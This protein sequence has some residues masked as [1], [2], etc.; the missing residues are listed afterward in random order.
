MS[1]SPSLKVLHVTLHSYWEGG[2]QV[3]SIMLLLTG[4][5]VLIF[6]TGKEWTKGSESE[7]KCFGFYGQDHRS[8]S[9][10]ADFPVMDVVD[11]IL[12]LSARQQK[13]CKQNGMHPS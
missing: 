6:L 5:H 12:Q 13:E 2:A 1:H 9:S 7:T 4:L 10:F 3:A 8:P 11:A